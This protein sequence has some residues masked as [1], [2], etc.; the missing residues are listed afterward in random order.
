MR[1]IEIEFGSDRFAE[2]V[3]L[4]NR[5]LRIPLGLT[6]SEED[7]Q[8]ESQQLHF[9]LADDDGKL[10]ACAIVVPLDKH[11]VKLRQMAVETDRQGNGFGAQLIAAIECELRSRRYQSITLHARCTAIEFYEKQGYQKCGSEFTEVGIS[12]WKMTKDISS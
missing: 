3:D 4:R 8:K 5:L 12:H 1:L 10:V 7:L 11:H 2:E 6:F 9:G